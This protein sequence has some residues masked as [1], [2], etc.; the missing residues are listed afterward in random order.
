MASE[1]IVLV[2]GIDT[3]RGGVVTAMLYDE[4]GFPKAHEKAVATQTEQAEQEIL[5][6]RFDIGER[7][8]FAIKIHHDE[9]EDG[10]VTKNWTGI[11]PKEGLGF[12]NGGGIGMFGPPS[13]KTCM[14]Y[15][16]NARSPIKILI[17]YP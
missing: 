9:N 5:E 16:D 6:Y 14:L 7:E 15:A 3:A 12:S 4:D 17:S 8:H 10:N 2:E 11:I 13:Y 1:I